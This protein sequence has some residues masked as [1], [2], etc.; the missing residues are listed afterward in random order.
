MRALISKL[1]YENV[2]VG[3]AMHPSFALPLL[4]SRLSNVSFLCDI[5]TKE[6]IDAV[7]FIYIIS[8]PYWI[9]NELFDVFILQNSGI[10]I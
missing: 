8:N 1:E 10:S 6:I 5:K 9:A 2:S 4:T 7:I 3:V